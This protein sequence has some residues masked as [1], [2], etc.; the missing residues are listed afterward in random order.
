MITISDENESLRNLA[1]RVIKV[2]IQKYGQKQIDLLLKPV[3][4]GVFSVNYLKRASSGLLLEDIL[5][6]VNLHKNEI[7]H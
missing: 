7:Y 1:L 5:K 3:L 2:F 4:E 6:S